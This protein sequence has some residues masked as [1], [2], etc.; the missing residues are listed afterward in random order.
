MT[1]P[2]RFTCDKPAALAAFRGFTSSMTTPAAVRLHSATDRYQGRLTL[3]ASAR[4]R[5]PDQGPD[6]Q[7]VCAT[8]TVTAAH[9][10]D[11]TTLKSHPGMGICARRDRIVVTVFGHR[12]VLTSHETLQKA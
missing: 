1:I 2:S 6:R 3:L 12:N 4:R 8:T 9:V 7:P 5:L 10:R 11:V